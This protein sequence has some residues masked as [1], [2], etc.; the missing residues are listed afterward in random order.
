MQIVQRL[1]DI[2]NQ[3]GYLPDAELRALARSLGVPLG[4]IE[5]ITT[6]FPAFRPERDKPAA[7]EVRV[8]R[9]VSCHLRGGRR[10]VGRETVGRAGRRGVVPGPVRPRAGGVGG[11]APDDRRR[12]R[13][14]VRRAE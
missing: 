1:R 7:L 14:G 8:C 11:T 6:F 10:E 5:E 9:D 2:Q 12:T 3:F 4:R 13:L